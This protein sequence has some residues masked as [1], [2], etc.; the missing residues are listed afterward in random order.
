MT[1][2]TGEAVARK[3]GN[4]NAAVAKQS[5]ERGRRRRGCATDAVGENEALSGWLTEGA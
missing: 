4:G 1:A 5:Q 2:S 3:K